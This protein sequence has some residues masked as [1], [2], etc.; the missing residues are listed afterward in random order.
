MK[1]AKPTEIMVVEEVKQLP[2]KVQSDLQASFDPIFKEA[3]KWAKDAKSI[4][5]TDINDLKG[6]K[7]ARETRLKLKDIRTE[8]ENTRKKLKE[9]SL[10]KGK[11]IDGMAN[12]IK[13]LTIPLEKELKEQEKFAEIQEEKRLEELVEKRTEQLSQYVPDVTIYDLRIMSDEAFAQLL[14][15]QKQ[16]YDLEQKR[17]ADRIEKERRTEI[18]MSIKGK[19]VSWGIEGVE[20][21]GEKLIDVDKGEFAKMITD[22]DKTIAAKVTSIKEENERLKAE[23]EEKAE[24]DKEESEEREAKEAKRKSIEEQKEKVRKE[25]DAEKK[26]KYDE[27]VATEKRKRE[28]IENKIKAEKEAKAKGEKE[29]QERQRQA[30]LAPDKD[31]LKVLATQLM[32][33]DYPE[34]KSEEAKKILSGVKDLMKKVNIY[35][36]ENIE[37]L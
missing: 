9:E 8:A 28:A 24:K 36:V 11:A 23:S 19:I 4:K 15:A 37:K 25:Q 21:D 1:V 20:V 18:I 34:L 10:L 32:D 12:I 5:V 7:K 31:K 3:K 29:E 6:M 33:V 2:P 30:K 22:L 14:S 27:R 17:E 13:F 26:R 35:I 16:L